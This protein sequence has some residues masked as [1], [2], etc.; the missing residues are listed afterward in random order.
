MAATGLAFLGPEGTQTLNR[1][2]IQR[3]TDREKLTHF[4]QQC[5]PG[6]VLGEEG[7]RG[8]QGADVPARET[9][10]ETNNSSWGCRNQEDFL[11]EGG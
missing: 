8:P 4:T 3:S 6:T 5:V 2:T 1:I 7:G 9:C 10:P 11:E